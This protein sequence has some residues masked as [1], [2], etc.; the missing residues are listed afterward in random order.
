MSASP[1]EKESVPFARA[2]RQKIDQLVFFVGGSVSPLNAVYAGAY[3]CFYRVVECGETDYSIWMRFG[4]ERGDDGGQSHPYVHIP[5]LDKSIPNAKTR[6]LTLNSA[7]G[8][9]APNVLEN[10]TPLPC[11]ILKCGANVFAV[12]VLIEDSDVHR[13]KDVLSNYSPHMLTPQQHLDSVDGKLDLTI[14]NAGLR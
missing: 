10:V 11:L 7:V 5:K 4:N 12:D 14:M 8:E 9:K 13:F 2:K 6:Y 3:S 1:A